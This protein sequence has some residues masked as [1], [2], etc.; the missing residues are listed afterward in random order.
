MQRSWE[1]SPP[2]RARAVAGQVPGEHLAFAR[3]APSTFGAH[4][5]WLAPKPW[6]E[7]HRA[8]VAVGAPWTGIRRSR[9]GHQMLTTLEPP[10]IAGYRLV[11]AGARDGRAEPGAPVVLVTV[12]RA[13]RPQPPRELAQRMLARRAARA[14]DLMGGAPRAQ[15]RAVGEQLAGGDLESGGPLRASPRR[16]RRRAR[17]AGRSRRDA[18]APPGRSRS[19]VRTDGARWRAARRSRTRRSSAPAISAMRVS[20]PRMNSSS[21]FDAGTGARGRAV[22]QHRVAR[23]TGEVHVR[24]DRRRPRGRPA[25]ARPSRST[26]I[27]RAR[28]APRHAMRRSPLSRPSCSAR[29]SRLPPGATVTSRP[30]SPGSA[31]ASS[32]SPSSADL[33]ALGR[34]R[35]RAAVASAGSRAVMRAAPSPR[36]SAGSRSCRRG[37]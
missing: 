5:A 30:R 29:L 33:G 11:G 25:T 24:L 16:P 28:R 36:P 7:Q 3:R 6:R 20:A 34:A 9:W 2:A 19:A 31:R 27:S 35:A 1:S 22:E 8:A 10:V 4:I 12:L 17:S 32:H 21:A 37:S 23:V 18:A 26:A 13:P 15:R 14:Q